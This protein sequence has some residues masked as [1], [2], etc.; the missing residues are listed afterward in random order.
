QGDPA[1][2]AASNTTLRQVIAAYTILGDPARRARYDNRT[3]APQTITP[4]QTTPAQNN[5]PPP[6]PPPPNRPPEP[7]P[8]PPPR[9][10]AD[11]SR[12]CALAP[13]PP[14]TTNHR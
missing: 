6:P 10:A 3:T 1:A 8:T 11:P 9:P 4:H 2:N 14:V 12:P 5:P 7:R 13:Q